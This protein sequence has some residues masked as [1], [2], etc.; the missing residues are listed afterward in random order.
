VPSNRFLVG[1]MLVLIVA[2]PVRAEDDFEL[3]KPQP[4]SNMTPY[5]ESFPTEVQATARLWNQVKVDALAE[6]TAALKV[7]FEQYKKVR[8]ERQTSL[9]NHSGSLGI[10]GQVQPEHYPA[11]MVTG[12][13]W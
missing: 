9:A 7:E 3:K 1:L 11:L 2:A 8:F 12:A 10:Q 5:S 6:Q 13:R 4:G